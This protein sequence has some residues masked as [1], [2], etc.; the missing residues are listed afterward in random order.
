MLNFNF[1]LSEN[2]ARLVPPNLTI[3]RS[4]AQVAVSCP[5]Y[6]V[7]W[8]LQKQSRLNWVAATASD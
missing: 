6:H 2:G 3:E 1:K 7:E 4:G 5:S 8:K